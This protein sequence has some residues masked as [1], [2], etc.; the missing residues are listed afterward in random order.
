MGADDECL[1]NVTIQNIP[2]LDEIDRSHCL[3]AWTDEKRSRS[4]GTVFVGSIKDDKNEETTWL[5][6]A[7]HNVKGL[8]RNRLKIMKNC[9]IFFGNRHGFVTKKQLDEFNQANQNMSGNTKHVLLKDIVDNPSQPTHI[10]CY[11][12]GD[13][14][15]EK[16]LLKLQAKNMQHFF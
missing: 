3:L 7:G 6:T 1:T 5:I 4:Y 10:W 14:D 11:D 16:C 2:F 12:K 15:E 13:N 8:D 9:E